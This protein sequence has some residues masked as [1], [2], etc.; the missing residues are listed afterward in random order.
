MGLSPKRVA[1]SGCCE[2]FQRT[3]QLAEDASDG[4]S[5]MQ[6]MCCPAWLR[7]SLRCEPK[8]DVTCMP[9]TYLCSGLAKLGL[10]RR[11]SKP[12]ITQPVKPYCQHGLSRVGLNP[13]HGLK[14]ELPGDQPIQDIK[15][16]RKNDRD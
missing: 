12:A 3:P 14:K 5:P 16:V 2:V 6:I 4:C 15:V 7:Q 11:K 9:V 8:T 13:I 1:L 10:A